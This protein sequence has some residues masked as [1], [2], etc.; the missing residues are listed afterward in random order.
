M[1]DVNYILKKNLIKHNLEN[2]SQMSNY[3]ILI[4]LLE[5]Y[6]TGKMREMIVAYRKGLI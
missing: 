1:E 6:K 5:N 2:I 3:I 4:L